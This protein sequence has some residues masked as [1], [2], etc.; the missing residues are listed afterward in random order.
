MK[1]PLRQL[2]FYLMGIHTPVRRRDI[3]GSLLRK[4]QAA[5]VFCAEQELRAHTPA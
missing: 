1:L 4:V 3:G 2:Y 5:P